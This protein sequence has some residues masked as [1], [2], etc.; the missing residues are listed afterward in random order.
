MK[1]ARLLESMN[2]LEEALKLYEEIKKDYPQSAE[3]TTVDRYIARVKVK[4]S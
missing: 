2:K 1:A 3:G 4:M